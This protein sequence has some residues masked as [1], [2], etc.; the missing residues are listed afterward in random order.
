MSNSKRLEGKRYIIVA[1]S[2]SDKQ[3]ASVPDQVR[4]CRQYGDSNGG[5][6]VDTVELIGV[7]A[8]NFRNVDRY[9][10]ELIDRKRRFNDFDVLLFPDP[11]R[12]ARSGADHAGKIVHE[13]RR[14]GIEVVF[15]EGD[16]QGPYGSMIRQFQF[17]LGK[18]QVRRGSHNIARGLTSALVEGRRLYTARRPYGTALGL[19]NASGEVTAIY[20]SRPDGTQVRIDATTGEVV[21]EFARGQR[22]RK[23]KFEVPVLLPGDP[24][25]VETVV[26]IYRL[27]LLNDVGTSRIAKLL[28]QQGRPGPCGLSWSAATIQRV[29]NN[30]IYSGIVVAQRLSSARFHRSGLQGPVEIDLGPDDYDD[31]TGRV[32]TIV[33]KA[34]EWFRSEDEQMKTFLPADVRERARRHH[35]A[36]LDRQKEGRRPT[37]RRDAARSSEF[38]L[39]GLL[40]SS[41]GDHPMTG[42]QG[43]P[44]GGYRYYRVSPRIAS[45]GPRPKGR[46]RA[47]EV[48]QAVVGAVQEVLLNDPAVAEMLVETLRAEY[49]LARQRRRYRA[50]LEAEL[51]E[52]QRAA[53]AA[54]AARTQSPAAADLA[55]SSLEPRINDIR[56]ELEAAVPEL[57]DEEVRGE[58]AAI[59]Q[60]MRSQTDLLRLVEPGRAKQFLQGIIK[61]L[62]VDLATCEIQMALRLPVSALEALGPLRGL[63]YPLLKRT[64]S[65]NAALSNQA[66]SL[67][68]GTCCR[69]IRRAA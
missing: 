30:P 29:L 25:T 69:R 32:H 39:A 12:L 19:V 15:I 16:V 28:N 56:R 36:L 42:T 3:T 23:Q 24:R 37:P 55:L 35:E 8:S 47:A 6:Y 53:V 67:P 63:L 2:S 18:E 45:S 49:D 13:M 46:V 7:P 17:E 27:H 59:L 61:S 68:R 62:T 43:G 10:E 48:E 57:T 21:Q 11:L 22:Y 51:G 52:L 58:A 33:R 41:V 26:R 38:L 64:Q 1:R 34:E 54:C 44:D 40:R 9:I 14:A 31:E 5:V 60:W 20:Q 66:V 50:E 4:L 65:G